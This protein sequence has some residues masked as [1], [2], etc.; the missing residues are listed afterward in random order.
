MKREE[1]SLAIADL[2]DR[3]KKADAVFAVDYR[4]ILTVAST[5]AADAAAATT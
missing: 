4:E 2:S 3:L 1:E 5:P